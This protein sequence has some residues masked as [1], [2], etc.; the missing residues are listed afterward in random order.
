MQKAPKPAEELSAGK[1]KQEMKKEITCPQ[2]TGASSLFGG[3]V[4]Y[5]HGY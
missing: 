4:T 5:L 2:S 1:K 3:T